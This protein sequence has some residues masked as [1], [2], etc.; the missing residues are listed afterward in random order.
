MGSMGLIEIGYKSTSEGS[1]TGASVKAGYSQDQEL[2]VVYR[3]MCNL[4]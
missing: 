2:R 1:V 3:I 4:W